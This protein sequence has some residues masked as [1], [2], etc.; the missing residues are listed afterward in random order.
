MP[1][2]QRDPSRPHSRVWRESTA[3]RGAMGLKVLPAECELPVPDPPPGCDW[4]AVSAERR[5]WDQI[6]SGPHGAF[7]DESF[8]PSVALYVVYTVRV[9][10]GDDLKSHEAQALRHLANDLGMTPSGLRSLGFTTTL[11]EPKADLRS[12]G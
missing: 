12:V 3:E 7:L 6:F 9:L 2:P 4:P 11:P 8:G 1:G 10:R 5:L